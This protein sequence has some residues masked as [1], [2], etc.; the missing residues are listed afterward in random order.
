MPSPNAQ[1]SGIGVTQPEFS[2]GPD[3]SVAIP[4]TS[5]CIARGG[6]DTWDRIALLEEVTPAKLGELLRAAQKQPFEP[7]FEEVSRL[8]AAKDA[9]DAQAAKTLANLKHTPW[10]VCATFKTDQRNR[11]NILSCTAFVG[12]A[13]QPGTSREKLLATLDA[14]GCSY[15]VATSTSH[16]CQGQAR[17]RVVIPLAMPLAPDRYA[18]LWEHMNSRLRGVLDPGAKDPTRLNYMPR[19]P[20]GASGHEVIVVDDRPWL[21]TSAIG[22]SPSPDVG[23]KA[24]LQQR[25]GARLEELREFVF[26][27]RNP[28]DSEPEWWKTVRMLHFETAGS[29]EGL[30]LADEWSAKGSNYA[31]RAPIEARWNSPSW[32]D[33]MLTGTYRRSIGP[34]STTRWSRNL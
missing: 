9:G 25:S 1:H 31:G 33:P 6:A 15:V 19:E 34:A 22:T 5:F 24:I 12:D 2:P 3:Q 14:L 17:Y 16:G 29:P 4:R 11:K 7:T 32:N 13:D 8:R 20:R 28:S 18:S 30:S 10:F 26:K 21:D 23:S 27:R